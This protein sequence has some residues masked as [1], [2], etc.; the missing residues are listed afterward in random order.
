MKTGSFKILLQPFAIFTFAFFTP[1]TH[2]QLTGQLGVLDL[3]ANGGLNPNTNSPWA[4]GDQYRLVFIT[5]GTTNAQ[6][7]DINT[8]NN[9]A[10]SQAAGST[11]FSR[12]GEVNWFILGSTLTVDARDNTSTNSREILSCFPSGPNRILRRR[13]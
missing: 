10:T 11:T 6:S 9:F 5:S 2:A 4:E 12:L 1:Y 13:I 8:Y 7:A 3:E